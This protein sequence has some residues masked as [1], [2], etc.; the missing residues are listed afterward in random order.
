MKEL[1]D[2]GKSVEEAAEIAL[3]EAKAKADKAI[4][5]Y[6]EAIGEPCP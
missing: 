5:E 6:R 1:I 2:Q 4:C 3:K